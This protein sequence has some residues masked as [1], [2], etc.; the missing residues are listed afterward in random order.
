MIY[1]T[2]VTILPGSLLPCCTLYIYIYNSIYIYIYPIHIFY[3][4]I[5]VNIYIFTGHNTFEAYIYIY[6]FMIY[7]HINQIA[8]PVLYCIVCLLT[9]LGYCTKSYVIQQNI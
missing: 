8:L 5:F 7:L 3:I 4:Y 1:V 2:F 9:A 6:I